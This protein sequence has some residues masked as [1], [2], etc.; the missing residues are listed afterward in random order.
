MRMMIRVSTWGCHFFIS[1]QI[2]WAGITGWVWW[3]DEPFFS[4][5]RL[6]FFFVLRSSFLL[7]LL[8][9]RPGGLIPIRQTA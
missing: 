6:N 5:P 1:Y 9:R 7:L 8:C 2:D 3:R 4:F